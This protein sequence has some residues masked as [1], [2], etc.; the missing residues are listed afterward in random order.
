MK[1]GPQAAAAAALNEGFQNQNHHHAGIPRQ[2]DFPGQLVMHGLPSVPQ[3]PFNSDMITHGLPIQ[4]TAVAAPPSLQNQQPIYGTSGVENHVPGHILDDQ[5]H[6]SSE[7]GG[8]SRKKGSSV[9]VT[10]DKELR[11]LLRQHEGY[12]LKQMAAEVNKSEGSG[13]GN[14][15]KAKQVFAMIW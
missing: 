14:A 5:E 3:P 15:E 11:K 8:G 9:A 10:N 7:A 13:G 1:F 2:G 6:D 12:T 4:T